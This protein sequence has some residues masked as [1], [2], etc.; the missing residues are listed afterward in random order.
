MTT[1]TP[2]LR[3]VLESLPSYVPGRNVPGAVKLASNETPLAP[4]P[5]VLERIADAAGTVN[6]YPDNGSVALTEALA[7]KYGVDPDQVAVGCGSVSVCTQLVQAAADADDEV[8]Y[9]WRSFEAYPIITAVSGASSIQ[10]PLRDHVHDLHAMAASVTGKTR[11]VFVCNPNNP[12]GTAVRRDELVEFLRSVPEDVVVALDEAYREFVRDPDVPD[13]L[14]LL[15][16]HPNL[17]VLRTFSKAYGLA[18]LRVGYA[19]A[20]D[21]AIIAGLR[22][23]QVPFAV[24]S[25]AQ[26]A[27]LASL[28]P[29]AERQLFTRVDEIV[30]ERA[31][32][33]AELTGMGYPVPPSEANF[34]W[35]PL[36]DDTVDWAA[37]CE[38]RGVIVRAFA[39]SGA[40]VTI[41]SAD[42]NDRFLSAA[43]ELA[44]S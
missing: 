10:V 29:A 23:T 8:L 9:A 39:G 14:T 36:G 38:S 22:Q 7:E 1:V 19:I 17:V 15:D 3:P 40:R 5:H 16:E 13:G 33:Y 34:V 6:R 25:I 31:R 2:R 26:A 24:S 27:A 35:L 28:E 41:G 44:Q 37:G 21:P 20:H 11:V 4:L 32:V 30:A 12:T 18:G 42:E 43:R